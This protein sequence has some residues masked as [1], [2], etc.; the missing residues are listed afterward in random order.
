MQELQFQTVPISAGI[1]IVAETGLFHN[2]W[3]GMA[4][5]CYCTCTS[6]PLYWSVST[7]TG[8][9]NVAHNVHNA[10]QYH[11]VTEMLPNR[12]FHAIP[13]LGIRLGAI[14]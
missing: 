10:A 8:E 11:I 1:L 2:N 3:V 13:C 12:L 9:R 6:L 4:C 7:T 5:E 14:I